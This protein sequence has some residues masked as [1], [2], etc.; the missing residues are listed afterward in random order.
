MIGLKPG[1]CSDV[2]SGEVQLFTVGQDYDIIAHICPDGKS[3]CRDSA[4]CCPVGAGI[5]GCCPMKD[6]V[7]C[8]DHT[9]CCPSATKCDMENSNI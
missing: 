7:C 5:Y 8:D 2:T 1:F 4:T 6:A 3:T 9:H